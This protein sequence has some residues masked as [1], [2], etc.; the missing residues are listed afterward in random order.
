MFLSTTEIHNMFGK[1]S[2][3]GGIGFQFRQIKAW[4][5]LQRDAF[6]AGVD[7]QTLDCFGKA[8]GSTSPSKSRGIEKSSFLYVVSFAKW[9]TSIIIVVLEHILT[10]LAE[11]TKY[12]DDGTTAYA[13][14]HVFRRLKAEAKIARAGTTHHSLVYRPPF[15]T[16][17]LAS[18]SIS[19]FPHLL[20]VT[21]IHTHS[22]KQANLVFVAV[23][24]KFGEGTTGK[25][26]ST[27]FERYALFPSY[28]P[29]AHH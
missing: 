23:A 18:S 15:S 12:F 5:K 21:T 14:E 13:L 26:I 19:S 9:S 6:E 24:D 29:L 22:R 10:S 27:R 3:P 2:T 16:N 17:F 25:A 4:A 11:M 28:F 7:P 20:P 1:D 8:A